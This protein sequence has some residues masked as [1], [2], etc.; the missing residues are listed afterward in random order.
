[1][2]SQD[3]TI[4]KRLDAPMAEDG[5]ARDLF[6]CVYDSNGNGCVLSLGLPSCTRYCLELDMF[7]DMDIDAQR[8]FA[9]AFAATDTNGDGEVA[10]DEFLRVAHAIAVRTVG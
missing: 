4:L 9:E 6:G 8:S 5:R 10:V 1:M 2:Y 3:A 7:T